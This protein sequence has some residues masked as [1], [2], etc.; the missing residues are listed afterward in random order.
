MKIE[1]ENFIRKFHEVLKINKGL[2]I[3]SR[4]N[5][6]FT[7]ISIITVCVLSVISLMC[8]FTIPRISD[9]LVSLLPDSFDK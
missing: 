8:G 5:L 9:Q 1:D 7:K 2:N 4:L 6:S 3:H